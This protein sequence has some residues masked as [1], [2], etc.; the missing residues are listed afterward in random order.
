V[1]RLVQKAMLL[2]TAVGVLAATMP[3]V[4]G[5]STA[6]VDSAKG[7]GTQ[8]SSQFSF[9]VMATKGTKGSN[10]AKGKFSL[11]EGGHVDKGTI[12]CIDAS[13]IAGGKAA[14]FA[15]KLTK[16]SGPE[17]KGQPVDFDAFDSGQPNGQGD[18][19]DG[20]L[21]PTAKCV[22]PAAGGTP[23]TSGNITVNVK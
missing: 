12:S 3:G 13:N 17:V 22:T 20:A 7:K 21:V 16:T 9:K 8:T 18:T 2:L 11:S 15:G 14:N 1:S 10:P 4:A 6:K 5:A 23:I 19:F